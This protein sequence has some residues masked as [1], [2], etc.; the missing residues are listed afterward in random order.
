MVLPYA[1]KDGAQALLVKL[2]MMMV[3]MAYSSQTRIFGNVDGQFLGM[4]YFWLL[5]CILPVI[6]IWHDG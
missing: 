4:I 1:A 2:G 3:M 5:S 6:V